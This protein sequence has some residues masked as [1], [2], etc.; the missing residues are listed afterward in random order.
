MASTIVAIKKDPT[1]VEPFSVVWAVPELS[2][3]TL[4]AFTLLS[5]LMSI[6]RR[7]QAKFK[8]KGLKEIKLFLA[9]IIAL[10]RFFATFV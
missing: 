9:P 10:I 4:Q 1:C 2:Y 6:N 7:L 8:I 5:L 3:F